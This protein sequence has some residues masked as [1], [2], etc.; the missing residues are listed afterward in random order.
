MVGLFLSGGH[1]TIGAHYIMRPLLLK[2]SNQRVY[3]LIDKAT[4]SLSRKEL[5]NVKITNCN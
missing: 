4:R 2:L 1:H 3:I 5:S